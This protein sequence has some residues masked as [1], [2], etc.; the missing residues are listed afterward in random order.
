MIQKSDKRDRATLFRTRLNEALRLRALMAKEAE[1][2]LLLQVGEY[3]RGAD[4][5]ADEAIARWPDIQALLRQRAR[6]ER[7]GREHWLDTLVQGEI[8]DRLSAINRRFTAP[9]VVTG[10]PDFWAAAMPAP[11]TTLS[12]ESSLGSITTAR[13]S[14]SSMSAI[15]APASRARSSSTA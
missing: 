2:R 9:A 11:N 3:Q 10:A 15:V 14:L 13:D 8:E 1:I 4:A 7:L 5:L 6:A 12:P